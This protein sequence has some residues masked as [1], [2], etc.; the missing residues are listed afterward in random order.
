MVAPFWYLLSAAC[1]I[2]F[3]YPY[4][5][6]PLLLR[7]FPNQPYRTE[8]SEDISNLSAALL[9]CAFNE[10]DALPEKIRNVRELKRH[11]PQ[12]H[13]L[14][15]SD[16]SEDMT[17]QILKEA[18]DVLTPVL[19][20]TRVGKVIGMQ[21]LVAMT[22]QD[23]VV[24]TDANVI[25]EPESL[26]RIL[27]YFANQDIGAVAGTL[28]YLTDEGAYEAPT[29]QVGSL[30]WR[31]EEQIKRLE[32]ET[33]STMGADG[34][35]FARRRIGYPALPGDL[36]DDLAASISV[37]FDGH[38]CVSAP[39]VHAY[40]QSVRSSSEEFRRKR[41]I[42]CGSMS[43]YRYLLPKLRNLSWIDRFK[44]LSHK[45]LRW[46]GGFFLFFALIFALV[47]SWFAGLL[48]VT[49]LVISA[50]GITL[51]LLGPR[52]VPIVSPIYEILLAIIAT[53]IGVVESLSGRKYQT[54]TPPK[55]R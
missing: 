1:L 13:V 41:R 24:F 6:Y 2:V 27:R 32:S 31:L 3:V 47:G 23:I 46:S 40:E 12:L 14:A 9:F 22:E 34:S 21:K 10:E 16:C 25:L 53:G 52:G 15:Y 42:A 39:D 55:S 45:T 54:W 7:F 17:N 37:L 33:G 50:A 28:F 49:T 36:V 11:Y 26:P 8:G 5:I 51:W 30:Y 35:I 38:R 29:A 44:F 48:A 20:N 19:G 4:A 18:A 43:T